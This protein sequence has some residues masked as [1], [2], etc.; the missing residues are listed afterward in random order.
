MGNPI[1][2]WWKKE[3]WSSINPFKPQGGD[4]GP[5]ESDQALSAEEQLKIDTAKAIADLESAFSGYGLEDPN[6]PYF[7][8]IARKSRNFSMNAPVTGI[9]D[10]R[11]DAMS[12]LAFQ[13]ARQGKTDSTVRTDR[14]ALASKLYG[15]GQVDASTQGHKVGEKVRANLFEA[16][17]G[18][19][20]DINLATDPSSAAN[21]AMSKISAA[22]DPGTFNPILDVF[23]KLTQ[24]LAMRQEVERR[25]ERLA[26]INSYLAGDRSKIVT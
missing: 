12:Q 25:K 26:E 1:S 10:Q 18:G 5:S 8:N 4:T 6:S 9:R 16:K 13:L 21:F 24:G 19:L 23:L 7:K 20:S 17:E 14:D 3:D 2:N 22:T 11:R 15:K